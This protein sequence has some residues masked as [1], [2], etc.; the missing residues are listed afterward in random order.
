[1]YHPDYSKA[2]VKIE[3]TSDKIYP[4]LEA[5]QAATQW[6]VDNLPSTKSKYPYAYVKTECGGIR[7]ISFSDLD[8]PISVEDFLRRQAEDPVSL[9]ALF[10]NQKLVI[11]E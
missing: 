10:D 7:Y 1:M 4:T 11:V 6:I 5:A 3:H 9:P 8:T 2:T